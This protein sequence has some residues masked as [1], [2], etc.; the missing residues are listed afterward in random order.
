MSRRAV[1]SLIWF[2]LASA[3]VALDQW[4]KFLVQESIGYRTATEL[5]SFLNLT[6]TYNPGAAFSF[7]GDAGGWQRWL[8]VAIGGAVSVGLITWLI[9][10]P[11]TQPRWLPLSLTLVLGGAVGNVWDRIRLGV[12]VDFIDVHWATHHWPAF[13]VADT[14]ITL[15]AALLI[16]LSFRAESSAGGTKAPKAADS[17]TEHT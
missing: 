3:I 10:L 11:A 6:L 12:V 17:G 7:L 1:G 15:G 16:W 13:N 2:G 8:F 9:R 5:T 14:S 4:T